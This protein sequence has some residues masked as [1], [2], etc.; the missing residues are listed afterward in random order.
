MIFNEVLPEW[1]RGEIII[2]TDVSFL[3]IDMIH[4]FLSE[5]SYWAKERTREQTQRAIENSLSF[6]VYKGEKQIGF[7]RVVTDYATF[8]YIGD[9]FILNEFRGRGISKWLMETIV[10]HPDLQ[11]LRRWILAT[12]DAHALYEKFG[13]TE[14]KVPERWM[15]KT[16]PN[17]Y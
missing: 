8:A 9:V 3:Q 6:G 7:A 2:R 16:A 12:R 14:L 1:E 4:K 10:N 11:N 5:E 13:F 15:E 17:A